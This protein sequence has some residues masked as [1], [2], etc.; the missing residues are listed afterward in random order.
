M[1]L[2]PSMAYLENYQELVDAYYPYR[3]W[4]HHHTV[5]TDRGFRKF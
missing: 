4:I 1:S 3:S 5:K 2:M